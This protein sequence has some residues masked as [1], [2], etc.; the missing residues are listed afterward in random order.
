MLQRDAGPERDAIERVLGDL[1]LHAGAAQ[2]QLGE[3]Y[4]IARY[5]R[6]S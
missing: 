6:S 1:C 2:Y 5:R 3:S 4:A